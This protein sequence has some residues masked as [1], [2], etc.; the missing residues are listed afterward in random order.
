MN[1]TDKRLSRLT[2]REGLVAAVVL[3]ALVAMVWPMYERYSNRY[4]ASWQVLTLRVMETLEPY[5]EAY[6]SRSGTYASGT[7]DLANE[8]ASIVIATGWTPSSHDDT[9]YVVTSIDE[10]S[11]KVEARRGDEFYVCRMFPGNVPCNSGTSVS[12]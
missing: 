12:D 9:K 8:D 11:Y 4:D 3:V 2:L 6:F 1:P 10:S 7:Y 5:Q